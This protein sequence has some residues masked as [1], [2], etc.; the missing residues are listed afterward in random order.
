[1][2]N[3][4]F[5][6]ND[7]IYER[8]EET[9]KQAGVTEEFAITKALEMYIKNNKPVKKIETGIVDYDERT[10]NRIVG[11]ASHP[12]Q[13]NHKILKSFFIAEAINGTGNVSVDFLRGICSDQSSDTYV[14]S[15]S[16]NY[17]QMK[18]NAPKSHGKVFEE[19]GGYV[20][21]YEGVKAFL[22]KYKNQFFDEEKEMKK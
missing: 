7:D 3:V 6:C 9:Y 2:I 4:S 20:E 5:S 1:M 21:I 19:H 8:F 16:S 10:R 14:P 12:N 18:I 11:W 22:L 17:S 13:Y 15:F